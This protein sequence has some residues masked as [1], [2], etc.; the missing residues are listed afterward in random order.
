MMMIITGKE[1]HKSVYGINLAKQI[2]SSE[3]YFIS[4]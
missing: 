1:Y 4:A 3:E 2:K